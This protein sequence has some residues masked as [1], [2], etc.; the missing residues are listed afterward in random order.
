M[1][2][3]Q[4]PLSVPRVD[5]AEHLNS[6]A[7]I[8]ILEEHGVRRTIDSLIYPEYKYHPLTTVSLAHDSD[9]LYADFFVRCNYLRAINYETNSPV[10]EDSSVVICIQPNVE[11]EEYY[12]F[13]VNCIGTMAGCIRRPG[14]PVEYIPADV[15]QT[16]KRTPS[17]GTRP[18][19]EL[20]GLFAWNILL[21]IPLGIL[22]LENAEYPKEVKG[23]FYKCASG[24]SQPHFLSWIP[25]DKKWI[26]E[27]SEQDLGLI[28]MK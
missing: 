13:E 17:C 4:D 15:L 28:I 3:N 9:Y 22:S 23:N 14:K 26:E 6:D 20:E 5:G 25:V 7:L 12:Y 24:T 27:P 8:S 10:F 16:I 18:F 2:N 1:N 11:V 19:R 21:E